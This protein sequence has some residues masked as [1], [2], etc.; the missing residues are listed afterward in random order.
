MKDEHSL[1]VKNLLYELCGEG[2]GRAEIEEEIEYH[3]DMIQED[4]EEEG[5]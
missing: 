2:I 5:S 3:L 1:K 4:Q